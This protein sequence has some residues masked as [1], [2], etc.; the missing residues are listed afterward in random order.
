MLTYAALIW[1]KRTY[2]TTVKKQFAHIQ[3]ITCLG[4]SDC[5]STTPTAA[6]EVFLGLSSLQVVVAKEAIPA[7]Y[8]LHCSGHFKKSDWGHSAIYKEK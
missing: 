4:I 1:W 8:R 3:C 5:T 7:A 6:L 2:L